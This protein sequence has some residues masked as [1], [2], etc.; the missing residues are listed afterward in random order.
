[1]SAQPSI[2][3]PI[4]PIPLYGLLAEFADPDHLVVAAERAHADG[5]RRMDAYA[6]FPVEG[7]ADAIG[8]R[9]S[10]V[11]YVVLTFGAIGLLTGYF[12]QLWVASIAYPINIGGRPYNSIP[13]F[14]PVTFELTILFAAL[15]AVVCQFVLNR[16]PEPYH[17]AF[18]IAAFA[19]VTTDRF[20]LLIESRDPRFEPARTAQFLRS[21][22]AVEV[23]DVPE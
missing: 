21:Q 13:S 4:V 15:S 20:F 10:W 1:M 23:Y 17:P 12:F 14:V 18:N 2:P 5:Y 11:P 19:R 3:T 22:G 8:M 16:L 9:R 6:P 7:L